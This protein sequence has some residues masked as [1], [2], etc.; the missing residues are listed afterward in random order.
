MAF[1]P[2]LFF[3]SLCQQIPTPD[4]CKKNCSSFES[5][6]F[7]RKHEL[8]AVNAI[9]SPLLWSQ[10]ILYT[11]SASTFFSTV[12]TQLDKSVSKLLTASLLRSAVQKLSVRLLSHTANSMIG[13]RVATFVL[14][15]QLKWSTRPSWKGTVISSCR[16]PSLTLGSAFFS[17][18]EKAEPVEFL[19]QNQ[20]KCV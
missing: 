9:S 5:S 19:F 18:F 20:H 1:E 17:Y 10:A 2:T 8:S 3:S 7:H 16:L 4:D 11:I 15:L 14:G 6:Q 13:F 12:R